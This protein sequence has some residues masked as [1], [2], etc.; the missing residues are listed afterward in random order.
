MTAEDC[1]RE[2][3]MLLAEL[4]VSGARNLA[5]G[6]VPPLG[7]L[8]SGLFKPVLLEGGY[9]MASEHGILVFH[10]LRKS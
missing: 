5:C 4:R 7:D 2:I 8:L 1:L 9:H 6:A 10:A 3:C